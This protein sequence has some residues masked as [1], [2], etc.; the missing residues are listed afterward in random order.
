MWKDK[1]RSE[2]FTY[3]LYAVFIACIFLFVKGYQFNTDDQAEHLPQVYQ[4]I[5][6]DLYPHDYFVTEYHHT[7]SLRMFYV[8]L[9]YGLSFLAPI[10]VVCFSMTLLCITISVYSFM[11]I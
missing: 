7:Y 11:Q 3:I 10:S 9:V 1:L 6:H 8:W 4:L 2:T 5:D